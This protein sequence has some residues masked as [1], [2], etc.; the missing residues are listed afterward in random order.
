MKFHSQILKEDLILEDDLHITGVTTALG[1]IQVFSLISERALTVNEDLVTTRGSIYVN[2]SLKIGNDMI[3]SENITV[4][5][6]C[7]IKGNVRGKVIRF[8]GKS[9]KVYSI[10][11]KNIE[12]WGDIK[13]ERDINASESVWLPINPK[14]KGPSINGVINAPI[15]TISFLGFFTKWFLL[16]DII[17]NKLRIPTRMKKVFIIKNLSIEARKL[18][19]CTMYQPDRVDVQFI[20]SNI[21]ADN[22]E[23]IQSDY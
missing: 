4:E 12:L 6:A 23:F 11:G 10:E 21:D 19:I 20:D 3:S 2:N 1:S 17:L 7:E 16:P 14:K 9:V 13:V 15:V 8:N 18:V 5:G 22:I